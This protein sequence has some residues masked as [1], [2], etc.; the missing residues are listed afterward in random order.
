[1][2]PG[3]RR[4]TRFRSDNPDSGG[5]IDLMSYCVLGVSTRRHIASSVREELETFDWA[6]LTLFPI[7]PLRD[8]LHSL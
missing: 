4:D 2:L 8:E 6:T 3:S 1:M 7:D 5:L